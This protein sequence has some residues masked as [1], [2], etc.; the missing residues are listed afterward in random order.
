MSPS[1][2]WYSADGHF[3]NAAITGHIGRKGAGWEREFDGPGEMDAYM[4]DHWN[5]VVG[6]EDTV[7]Y[8][9]DFTLY[10]GKRML[11]YLD[12]LVG[13]IKF[14]PGGHDLKWMKDLGIKP[15]DGRRDLPR[16]YHKHEVLPM[17]HFKRTR[18]INKA[19]ESAK[20]LIVLSHYP[21]FTWEASHHGSWNLHGHS[22]GGLGKANRYQKIVKSPPTTLEDGHSIDVGVDAGWDF[23]PVHFE[24]IV[25]KLEFAGT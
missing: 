10:D 19:G 16:P 23:Y 1:E 12:R 25:D 15:D 21:F 17:V 24:T 13:R 3:G 5:E 22:H 8:L 2:I 20:Q 18:I 14:V 6:H 4:I 9:G 11:Q 7:Y